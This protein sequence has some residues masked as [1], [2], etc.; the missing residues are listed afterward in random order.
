MSKVLK[1][2][3]ESTFTVTIEETLSRTVTIAADSAEAAQD[4]AVAEWKA[5]SIVLDSSDFIGAAVSVGDSEYC[6]FA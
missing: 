2:E 6:V 5:G 1:T 4:E 3:P